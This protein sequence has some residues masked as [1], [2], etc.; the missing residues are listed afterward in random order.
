MK[1]IEFACKIARKTVLNANERE[2]L[3]K[4]DQKWKNKGKIDIGYDEKV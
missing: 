2:I 3:P 4:K 1:T